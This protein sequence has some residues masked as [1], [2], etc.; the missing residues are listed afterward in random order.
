MFKIASIA[1]DKASNPED[2]VKL[3]G[4]VLDKFASKITS[5][6]INFLPDTEYLFP[7]CQIVPHEFTSDPVPELVGTAIIFGAVT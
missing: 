4:I 7:L 6:G 3:V 2:I 1:C 5:D